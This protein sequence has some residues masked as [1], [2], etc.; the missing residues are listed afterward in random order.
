MFIAERARLPEAT[1]CVLEPEEGLAR[2]QEDDPE[3]SRRRTGLQ[4]PEGGNEI[5]G[6]ESY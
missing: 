1:Q 4:D 3:V 2:S 6:H 5:T